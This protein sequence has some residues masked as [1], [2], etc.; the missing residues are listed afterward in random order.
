MTLSVGSGCMPRL[1][2]PGR[3]MMLVLSMVAAALRVVLRG[4]DVAADS[5][6]A[7][8]VAAAGDSIFGT[9][10]TAAAITGSAVCLV[11]AIGSDGGVATTVGCATVVAVVMI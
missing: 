4:D 2:L 8:G 3:C 7:E 5:D 11:A 10:A 9:A 1:A 6:A